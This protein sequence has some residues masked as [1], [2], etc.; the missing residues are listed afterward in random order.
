MHYLYGLKLGKQRKLV[1]TFDS[2]PLL[3]SYVRW[4]TLNSQ[5]DG[6]TKFEQGSP[7]A[8]YLGYEYSPSPLY[9]DDP[10][11]VVHNPSPSML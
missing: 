4:A 7:L 2:E 9:D 8:G 6:T 11:E 10:T 1:A 3:L 5:S